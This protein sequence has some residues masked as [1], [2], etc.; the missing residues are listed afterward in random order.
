MSALSTD[1][2]SVDTVDFLDVSEES[3]AIEKANQ[4]AYEQESAFEKRRN[5]AIKEQ[6]CMECGKH[7]EYVP[8]Y[9]CSGFECGC[10]GLPI[11]PPVCDEC[12]NNMGF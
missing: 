1:V 9:C 6:K 4:S 10:G 8:Q 2:L 12:W 11:D 3:V 5:Y 7:I